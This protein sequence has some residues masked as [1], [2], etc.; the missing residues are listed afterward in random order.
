MRAHGHCT[1]KYP[2]AKFLAKM[3]RPSA[4]MFMNVYLYL[5]SCVFV[6]AKRHATCSND[7]TCNMLK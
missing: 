2:Y 5:L 4:F 1:D 3:A 7:H 6:C